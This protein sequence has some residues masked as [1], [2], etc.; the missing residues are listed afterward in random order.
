MKVSG[1][2][3]YC[4]ARPHP[5]EKSQDEGVGFEVASKQHTVCRVGIGSLLSMDVMAGA[6]A[7]RAHLAVSGDVCGCHHQGRMLLVAGGWGPWVLL[8]A[9]QTTGQAPATK[10]YLGP[11]VKPS[12]TVTAEALSL[13]L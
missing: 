4:L 6:V 3:A 8:N 13:N 12:S 9:L 11:H 7:W 2:P 10:H 1:R 5:R